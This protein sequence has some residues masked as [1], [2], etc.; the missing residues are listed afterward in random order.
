MSTIVSLMLNNGSLDYENDMEAAAAVPEVVLP[1]P[2][3]PPLL[4]TPA[5]PPP[6]ITQAHCEHDF[7]ALQYDMATAIIC[8]MYL[9]FG[10]VYSIFGEFE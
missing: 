10:V 6:S 1:P 9:I 4:P 7:L 8:A 5:H 3:L 2:H